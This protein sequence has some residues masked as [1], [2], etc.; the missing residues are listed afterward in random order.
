MR[1]KLL[2]FYDERA[3]KI[4]MVVVHAVAYPPRK[5]IQTFVDAKVSSHYVIGQDGEIWQLVGEKHRAWHAGKSFWR[6]A[7]DINSHAIGIELCSSSLG[8]RPF[9]KA[10]IGAV[11]ALLKRLIKKYRIRPENI[12]GH[13]DIAPARKPDPGKAFAWK[14]LA[15][16]GIGLW[17]DIKDAQNMRESEPRQLLQIIGYDTADLQASLVAFC[18]RFVPEKVPL[19]KD[20]RSLIECPVETVSDLSKDENV[21]KILKAV[22]YAYLS[23]SKTPCKI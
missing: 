21:L 8:Q 17:Y 10:Q 6:G 2:P 22:A 19:V 14:K 12:V 23:A 3:T 20:I 9:S 18:R 1:R 16:A 4:D 15:K 13:S 11:T 7:E 5:A